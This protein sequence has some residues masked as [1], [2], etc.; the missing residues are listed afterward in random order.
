MDKVQN[1]IQVAECRENLN[2]WVSQRSFMQDKGNLSTF[3]KSTNFHIFGKFY[4][5][6]TQ[7]YRGLSLAYELTTFLLY[8][9]CYFK[10]DSCRTN[11]NVTF[12]RVFTC[13]SCRKRI[14]I[15]IIP[16]I[17][18]K[19][20]ILVDLIWCYFVFLSNIEKFSQQ[21]QINQL[22]LVQCLRLQLFWF[23]IAVY[24]LM[25]LFCSVALITHLLLSCLVSAITDFVISLFSWFSLFLFCRW[26][27]LSL[28]R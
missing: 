3:K 7:V 22:C 14:I 25:F 4:S 9:Q 5:L 10:K 13:N 24:Y 1:K 28:F 21:R 15:N 20:N 19:M 11:D 8:S 16:K 6:S 26:S 2:R 23:Y 27:F 18:R 12:L 17:F